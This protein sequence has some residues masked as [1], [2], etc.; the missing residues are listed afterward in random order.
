MK[1]IARALKS[2]GTAAVALYARC[3]V[4]EYP[5]IDDAW[6][7]VFDSLAKPMIE[8]FS[9]T[10]QGKRTMANAFHC[11]DGVPFAYESFE[12]VTRIYMN[13]EGRRSKDA[14]TPPHNDVEPGPSCIDEAHDTILEEENVPG[15]EH[16]VDL[17]WLKKYAETVQGMIVDNADW[18]KLEE[19]IRKVGG[20]VKIVF[21]AFLVIGTKR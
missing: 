4:L 3:R 14:F 18:T 20:R 15:W 10:D 7:E 2:K 17:E 11:L 6:V 9:T 12:R 13:C 1:Q 8:R 19:S 16:F 21:P 5:A